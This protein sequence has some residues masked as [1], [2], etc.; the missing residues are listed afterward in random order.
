MTYR[1]VG[2]TCNNNNIYDRSI[3]TCTPH[4]W[5]NILHYHTLTYSMKSSMF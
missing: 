3:S 1:A 4:I 2:D 5:S